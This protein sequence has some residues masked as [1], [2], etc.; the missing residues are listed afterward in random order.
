[1][2]LVEEEVDALIDEL[3]ETA[4]V[5][6]KDI[7][8]LLNAKVT[9]TIEAMAA[10]TA[11]LVNSLPEQIS[12]VVTIAEEGFRD[13][14][15]ISNNIITSMN[16]QLSN[17]SNKM[18][19]VSNEATTMATQYIKQDLDRLVTRMDDKNQEFFKAQSATFA[20]KFR[21]NNPDA[22]EDEVRNSVLRHNSQAIVA[23]NEDTKKK[24]DCLVEKT[25]RAE[26]NLVDIRNS[27]N[28][29]SVTS[30]QGGRPIA[31]RTDV[32]A[33]SKASLERN[34]VYSRRLQAQQV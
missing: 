21:E 1:M 32:V 13:Q 8:T 16:T 10:E 3:N 30:A 26:A 27:S 20:A 22:T 17:L 23:F 11:K 15:N 7:D 5:T 28:R 4:E 25:R 9:G 24:R 29:N 12:G 2:K 14:K 19:D 6:L 34:C 33:K 18:P 31:N